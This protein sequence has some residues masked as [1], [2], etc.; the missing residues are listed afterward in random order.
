VKL[1]FLLV[2]FLI[3]LFPT[4]V[5]AATVYVDYSTGNDTT[6]DGSSGTPYKTFHKGYAEATTGD[7]LDLTGTFT[8]TN[9]DETGDSS[10]TGYT[11]AKN[12]T[13]EGQG[14]GVTIIQA[15]GSDNSADRRVLTISAGVTATINDLTIRYGKCTSS[16]GGVS[17]NG[18]LIINRCQINNNRAPSQSGGGVE[19]RNHL[20]INDSTIHHNVAYYKGGGVENSYYGNGSSNVINITNSTVA[21]NE[22]TGS[23]AYTEG[24][25]VYYRL[26]GGTLTNNTIVYNEGDSTCGLGMDDSSS[27]L[28]LKNNIIAGNTGYSDFGFRSSG[29]GNVV[30]GGGN[31]IG[32]T[33]NYTF[34]GANNWLDQDKNGVYELT[35][36]GTT[37]PLSLG[38]VLGDNSTLNKTQTLDLSS[39]SVAINTGVSGSNNGI[40][41]PNLDQRGL[42]RLGAVD[43]GAYEFGAVADSTDPVISS[44]DA[45]S[46]GSTSVTITW[47]TDENSSSQVEYGLTGSYGSSTSETDTS[48]RVTS[49]SV[50]INS[51]KACRRYFYRVKSTDGSSNQAVST[52]STFNTIGCAVTEV[53]VG[54]ESSI[55]TAAGGEFELSNNS[56]TAKLVIPDGFASE[57]ADFQ[58]NRLSTTNLPTAPSNT[59][60]ADENVFD[61][62]AVNASGNDLTSFDKNLT[63]TVTYGSNTE[64][65]FEESTLDVFKYNAGTSAWD[66]QN[67]TLDSVNNT[68]T[69]SLS[70]F[71]VYAVFGSEKSESDT[72]SSSDGL[73]MPTI[74]GC[75]ANA[76]TSEPNLFKITTTK[77]SATVYFSPVWQVNDY[78]ISY[79][80]DP[81]S[82]AY[83][84]RVTLGYEGV[85]KY[86]I[87]DLNPNQ[88]YYFKVRGQNDCA[89]GPWSQVLSTQTLGGFQRPSLENIEDLI[90]NKKMEINS[91]EIETKKSDLEKLSDQEN[92]E[93]NYD[94]EIEI[95][96]LGQPLV[97]AEV[98][99]HSEPRFAIT[100]ENGVARFTDVEKG[101]HSLKIAQNGYKARQKLNLTGD[102]KE[103]KVTLEVEMK[104]EWLPTWVWITV[105]VMMFFFGLI[106]AF[107]K[108]NNFKIKKL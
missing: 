98:E 85:Q 66:D 25:G 38:S 22:Q 16:G 101:E 20:T 41:V 11:I 43:I 75:L 90:S 103:V 47:T 104:K 45:T 102:D 83:G 65:G 54:E 91:I 13:I 33:Q 96:H 24:A 74:P 97:G 26:G 84:T 78:F 30:D 89:P 27:T 63:F 12:L 105:L 60:L 23:I 70:S 40:S 53:E 36:V 42:A 69:C 92:K 9:A 81:S 49:H 17:N 77:K 79:S 39:G 68:L 31:I 108:K 35:S 7:T 88:I 59:L 3:L 34:T 14:A 2:F 10:T 56:S 1:R 107:K 18:T 99:L 72:G 8:W 19:N 44:V 100:D 86:T 32:K 52:Q 87:N 15:H 93:E 95:K 28:Y 46:I 64:T 71:S 57:N 50:A 82:E 48:T 37:G 61:L 67:C 21:Y 73:V 29:Q 62:S 6:G 51:L 5:L 4:K 55:T 58:I 106:L 76:P 94:V 80:T